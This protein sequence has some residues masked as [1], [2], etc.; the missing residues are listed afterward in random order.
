M[1]YAGI[2]SD[3]FAGCYDAWH[4]FFRRVHRCLV[5]KALHVTSQKQL[6]L[7]LQTQLHPL[8]VKT[9]LA[10]LGEVDQQNTTVVDESEET[11]EPLVGKLRKTLSPPT[12]AIRD[13]SPAGSLPDFAFGNRAV[14]CRF[15][16][17]FLGE[18]PFPHPYI[19]APLHPRVS[20]HVMFR[21]DSHLRV[22]AGKPVTCWVLPRPGSTLHTNV[23]LTIEFLRANEAGVRRV[24]SSAIIKRGGKGRLPRKPADQ[25]RYPA[26][27]S[28]AD[29]DVQPATQHRTA[30]RGATGYMRTTT[31]SG[32]VCG[33]QAICSGEIDL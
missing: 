13:R 23:A 26:R 3:H 24:W 5:D 14:R 9:G 18:L 27:Y 20:F 28:H 1:K 7:H 4:E 25:Q 17:G 22:P 6:A 10:G 16:A 32:V 30:G 12:K 19:P 11:V 33:P 15:P 2:R 8:P 31:E 21:D 29:V